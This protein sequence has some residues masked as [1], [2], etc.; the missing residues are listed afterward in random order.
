MSYII[1]EVEADFSFYFDGD[2]FNENAGDFGYTVFCIYYDRQTYCGLNKE[3]YAEIEDEMNNVFYEI[4][5][6]IG[7]SYKNVKEVMTDYKL[8]YSPKNAHILKQLVDSAYNSYCP[9]QIDIFCKY[10]QI[11][12]GKKWESL[13]V[14]GYCQGDVVDVIYCPS[15]NSADNM[16]IL[17]NLFLGCGKEFGVIEIDENG[18]EIDSCYGYYVADCQTYKPTEYKRIVCEYVGI[19]ETDAKL[20]IIS[21]Y[22]NVADYVEY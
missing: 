2:C 5:E 3:A 11:K 7:Y 13:R 18:N 9:D 17:G 22:H 6:G 8:P 10:L 21:G 4:E 1:K 20:Q 19:D 12:T 15:F 14:T 16:E